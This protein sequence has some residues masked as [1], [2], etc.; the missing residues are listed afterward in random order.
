M[1]Q[2]RWRCHRSGGE[3]LLQLDFCHWIFKMLKK[4]RTC[5]DTAAGPFRDTPEYLEK[6]D[7]LMEYTD[8]VLLDIKEID[9]AKHKDLTGIPNVY[10]LR[11][12]RVISRFK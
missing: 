7:K 5:L 12:V 1:G 6:F 4:R 11:S 10:I 2:E 9:S 3:A 8:L